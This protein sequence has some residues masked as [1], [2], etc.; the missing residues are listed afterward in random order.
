MPLNESQREWLTLALVPGVGTTLFIRLLARFKTPGDVLRASEA[1]LEEVVGNNL[2]QRIRQYK[3]FVDLEGQV[4]DIDKY[5]VQFI[6]LDD[7]AYPLRLAEIYDPPLAL[8][9]RGETHESDR[10]CVAIVGTRGATGYGL[11]M[12]E[13]LGAELAARGI[14]V[15]SGMA[16]GIDTAAHRGALS[17]GGRTIAVLGCGVDVV[18]PAENADL[19]H[20]IIQHGCVMSPF[21]MGMKALKGNF[22]QRNRIISGLSLGTI[23]VEAPPGSGALITA[24]HAAEQGREVFAVPGQ[25][26][27]RNSM[28]PHSLIREGAK[29]VETVEDVLTELD[30]PAASR[31]P[32]PSPEKPPQPA[33]APEHVPAPKQHV[34]E[35][36]VSE[37]EKDILASLSTDGSFVDEIA[38]VCRI[39]ISEA[40][41]SLTMLELKGLVRQFSGKRFAPR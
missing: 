21:P 29:L 38:A 13:R 32:S 8:F 36:V 15:V 3:E 22:P 26:G 1:A 27:Q 35:P 40:L 19:M 11:R 18:F 14:T 7:P 2:A 41:S 28:G 34:P 39:S 16:Q 23:V 31:Q 25:A 17:S 24:R 6:T 20:Q 12:A 33:S 37:T 30:L 5:N 9:T 10:Y 4:R